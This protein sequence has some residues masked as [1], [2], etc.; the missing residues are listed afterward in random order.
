[1]YIQKGN[2]SDIILPCHCEEQ[3]GLRRG[4]LAE[5]NAPDG[6]IPTVTSFPRND[7]GGTPT[8]E[9]ILFQGVLINGMC[10]FEDGTRA[11]RRREYECRAFVAHKL[12]LLQPQQ[13]VVVRL[14]SLCSSSHTAKNFAFIFDIQ[15]QVRLFLPCG[16]PCVRSTSDCAVLLRSWRTKDGGITRELSLSMRVPIV[17]PANDG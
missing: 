1:M 7:K 4:N 15:A 2:E 16:S 14:G 13:I 17:S 11:A 8:P 3:R 6:W 9:R 5:R 10:N 12:L